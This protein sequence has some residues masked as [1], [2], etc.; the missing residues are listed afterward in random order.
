MALVGASR[1]GCGSGGLSAVV[2]LRREVERLRELTEAASAPQAALAQP[3]VRTV[4]TEVEFSDGG[5]YKVHAFVRVS[6]M[7]CIAPGASWG[8]LCLALALPRSSWPWLVAMRPARQRVI[9]SSAADP[10][11]SSGDPTFPAGRPPRQHSPRLGA[12]RVPQRGR[13]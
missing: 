6:A 5:K 13:V 10:V 8:T 12:P 4:E 1:G 7:H 3:V 11:L 2:E 9:L